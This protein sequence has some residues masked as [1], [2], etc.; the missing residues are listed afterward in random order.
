MIDNCYSY[1]IIYQP[2]KYWLILLNKTAERDNIL[3]LENKYVFHIPLYTHNEE[4]LIEIDIDD[5]LDELIKKLNDNGYQSFYM[6]NAK[7]FYNSR[8]FDELLIIIFAFQDDNQLK[9]NVIFKK[10]FSDNND[11]LNQ[12]SMAY[13]Y[14]N[15][16]YIEKLMDKEF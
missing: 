11:R 6:I 12:E 14:N 1:S 5:L 8:S 9:P 2:L 7:G 16:L 4:G 3:T 13:E 10:W 15:K